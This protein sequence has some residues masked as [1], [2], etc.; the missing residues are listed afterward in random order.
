MA[1]PTLDDY[2]EALSGVRE[3]VPMT[4]ATTTTVVG[5]PYDLW[6]TTAPIGAVPTT[7][8]VPTRATLGALGQQNAAGGQQLSIIG[9]RF[10]GLNPGVYIVADRLV[11]SGGIDGPSTGTVTTNMPTAALTRYTNGEGVMAAV[12]IYTQLNTTA[13]T[14]GMTYT[15]TVPT[16]SRV[17]PLV[18]IGATAFRE[19]NRMILLPLQEGDT[20]VRSVESIQRAGTTGTGGLF[21]ITL[22]K[23][24]YTICVDESS[25]VVSA[26]GFITGRTSGGIPAPVDDACLFLIAISA[27]TNAMGAGALLTEEN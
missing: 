8:A 2:R 20:G 4:V 15:N 27:G 18:A 14:V 21:G 6:R 25:G 9:A 7:S 11:H 12:T 13:S 17:G 5:R 19:A 16:G 24:L 22:F 26:S 10:N 1:I 3:I 23:P